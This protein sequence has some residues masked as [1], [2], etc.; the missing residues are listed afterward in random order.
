MTHFDSLAIAT[1]WRNSF[2][3]RAAAGLLTAV[4]A[5]SAN[6]AI[7]QR[8]NYDAV[9]AQNVAG[10]YTDLGTAGTAITTADFDDAN[11]APQ[12]IGFSFSFN[13]VS[14]AF[15]T[16]T[17]NTNGFIKLG[18][19]AP[20]TPAQY[21]QYAQTATVGGQTVYPGGPLSGSD[22]T[23]VNIIAPF[24]TDLME[25]TAGGTQ[26]RVATTGTVPN[27]V[28]TI[29]WKNVKDKPKQA[30][31]AD[32]TFIGTQYDN[33]SFQVKLYETT[34][35]VDFV[36]GTATAGSG[37][38]AFRTVAVGIKGS[39]ALAGSLVTINKGSTGLWSAARA[40][41]SLS[42]HN[43]RRSV[44]PDAGRT[45]RFPANAPIDA[46][47]TSVYTLGQLP[48][49][50]PH[51]VRAAIRNVGTQTLTNLPVQM[52]VTGPNSL[53]PDPSSGQAARTTYINVQTI[54]SLAPGATTVV[55]FAS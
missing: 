34:G 3:G 4:L 49:G 50:T 53:A 22:T 31:A 27:R 29:Q 7:A 45:Y 30:S 41:A 32:T 42:P 38:D 25:A 21:L 15:T 17:L 8:L 47:V 9:N 36:Y 16:F 40:F 28:C 10:T 5:L 26:Y 43:V 54:A 46:A 48:V 52:E 6:S 13:N 12:A 18:S 24:A 14:P 44:L 11:S 2:T 33:F 37:T 55:T 35:Q 23:S 1:E 39:S 51:A 19:V 20:S